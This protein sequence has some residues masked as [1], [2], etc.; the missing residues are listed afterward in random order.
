MRGKEK[1]RV[2]DLDIEFNVAK[3]N[4]Q[5][6]EEELKEEIHILSKVT[7]EILNKPKLFN[8]ATVMFSDL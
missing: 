6:A 2:L 8:L 5:I 1:L 4:L 3:K 7:C